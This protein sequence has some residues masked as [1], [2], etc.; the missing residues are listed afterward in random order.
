MK[1]NG[2]GR[3]TRKTRN[4]IKNAKM[5]EI[6]GK[7]EFR[8]F[9][10]CFF[11]FHFRSGSILH[12]DL[13]LSSGLGI[14][15]WTLFSNRMTYYIRKRIDEF[16]IFFCTL[17]SLNI[18][19]NFTDIFFFNLT[20]ST[21]FMPL[22]ECMFSVYTIQLSMLDAQFVSQSVTFSHNSELWT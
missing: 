13:G 10:L 9:L 18:S 22:M 17:L 11:C 4:N 5:L 12:M 19:N 8:I 16:L 21:T 6:S 14:F 2:M 3:W 20:S 7:W 1:W 15:K